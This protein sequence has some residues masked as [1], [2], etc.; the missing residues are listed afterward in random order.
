[1]QRDLLYVE[2]L[3]LD[4]HKLEALNQ[5]QDL[6]ADMAMETLSKPQLQEW[7]ATVTRTSYQRA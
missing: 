4:R 6:G 5:T 3:G 7:Q 1:M 2:E